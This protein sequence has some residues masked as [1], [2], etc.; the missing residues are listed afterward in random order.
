MLDSLLPST[1]VVVEAFTDDES[2]TC[3]EGEEDLIAS[4]VPGRRREFV[5]ARRCARDALAR[6]GHP[7]V[8]IRSGPGREPVWPAGLTGSITHCP[9]YRGAAVAR[10]AEVVS[11]GIDAEPH[12]PLPPRVLDVVTAPG[13]A[14]HLADLSRAEPAVHWDR[15]LFSAKEAVYKT[16]YPLTRRWL[17]FD[18]ANLTVDP[19]A[20]TF[21]ARVRVDGTRI[22]GGRPLTVLSGRYLIDGGLMLTAVW[23]AE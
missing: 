9:G 5:T 7:P 19:G 10:T 3:F 6:L 15:L 8:A 4:A 20:G 23:T 13:D 11:V 16:W 18:E 21:T 1:L 2:E 14:G 17:G 12:A 22:D